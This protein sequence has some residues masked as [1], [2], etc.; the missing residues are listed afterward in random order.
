VGKEDED[1]DFSEEIDGLHKE[2]RWLAQFRVYT[3][4]PFSHAALFN[5][6]SNA[7]SAAKEVTFKMLGENLFL[8]QLQCVGWTRIME[9]RPWL[10]P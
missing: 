5:A 9:G 10:F 8:V 1:L 4:K 7:W 3:T 2:V 6:I